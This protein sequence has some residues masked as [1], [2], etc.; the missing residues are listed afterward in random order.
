QGLKSG[1][2]SCW[3]PHF[4]TDTISA[5]EPTV[6]SLWNSRKTADF[7]KQGIVK[8]SQIEQDDLKFDGDM[9]SPLTGLARQWLQIEKVKNHD[10]SV[11]LDKAGLAEQL[12][13]FN[14]PLHFIDFETSTAALPFFKGMVPYETIAFQFSQH[15]LH[16]NGTVEHKTQFLGVTPGSFPNFDFVRALKQAL[17]S[18]EGTIFCY[19]KH[20]NTVLTH[21]LLQLERSGEQDKAGL[22]DFIK[23]ITKSSK[24]IVPGWQGKR[25][26]VDMLELVKGYYYDPVTGGSNSIKDVLPAMLARCTMLQ[27]IYSLPVYGT[28]TMP[29]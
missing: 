18:D 20:E 16:E 15:T 23:T 9:T 7:L 10:S 29:S 6:L 27:S 4:G 11:Y 3:H 2:E 22:I 13:K 25:V 5:E 19:S 26:M 8:L 12:A 28:V 1:F 24:D 14:Y 21:I 17:T